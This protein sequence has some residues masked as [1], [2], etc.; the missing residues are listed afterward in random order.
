MP[1]PCPCRALPGAPRAEFRTCEGDSGTINCPAGTTIAVLSAT[2][3]SPE[4]FCRAPQGVCAQTVDVAPKYDALCS[5]KASCA[6]EAPRHDW[7]AMNPCP[8][9]TKYLEIKYVCAQGE[10]GRARAPALPPLSSLPVKPRPA[11]AKNGCAEGAS[12]AAISPA[13][14]A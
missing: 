11:A 5:G 6:A 3:G 2:Y 12:H 13:A 1:S 9:Y 7:D 8:A 14:A 4:I 10:P